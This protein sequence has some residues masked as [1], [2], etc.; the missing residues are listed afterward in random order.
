MSGM[1]SFPSPFEAEPKTLRQH[2]EQALSCQSRPMDAPPETPEEEMDMEA[3]F[4][5]VMQDY[6][7]ALPVGSGEPSFQLS[8]D[9]HIPTED[10]ARAVTTY[11]E[12]QGWNVTEEGM[13][14]EKVYEI[15]FERTVD[16]T[17]QTMINSI[18]NAPESDPTGAVIIFS[19][20]T[21]N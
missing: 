17:T 5:A 16:E 2:L 3:L 4:A 1:E 7:D 19:L 18:N 8:P 14:P 6:E 9:H 20:R 10:I 15:K 21:D 12:A 13:R 11:Y